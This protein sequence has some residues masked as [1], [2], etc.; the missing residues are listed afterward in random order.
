MI[1]Q[2]HESD[3]HG[4]RNLILVVVKRLK[5]QGFIISD[6]LQDS[7][8]LSEFYSKIP[9]WIVNGELKVKEDVTKGLEQAADTLV[10]AFQGKNFGKPVIQIAND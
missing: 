5:L 2:Y 6:K 4:I 7:V 3:A 9:Q 10:R 8:F 1:S